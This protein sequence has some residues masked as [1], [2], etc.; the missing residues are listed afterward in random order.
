[1]TTVKRECMV[2]LLPTKK[3]NTKIKDSFSR[4]EVES[5]I[6]ESFYAGMRMREAQLNG[7]FTSSPDNWIESFNKQNL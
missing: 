6:V 4:E 5:F 2:M 7:D 1:M 3:E